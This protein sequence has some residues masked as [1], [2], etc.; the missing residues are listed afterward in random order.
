ML[1]VIFTFN[2][3]NLL[4]AQ[5]IPKQFK[6]KELNCNYNVK[7]GM[8]NGSYQ[9]F[10]P[11]GIKKSQGKFENNNRVERW[12]V[13]DSLG[14]EIC[15]R[16]YKNAIEFKQIFPVNLRNFNVLSDRDSN[17]LIK[18]FIV[19]EPMIYFYSKIWR[20]I[21]KENN[22]LLF[23]NESLSKLLINSILNQKITV[24]DIANEEFTIPLTLKQINEK[25][26]FDNLKINSFKIKEV[27]FMDT[28]RKISEVRILGICPI[29]CLKNDT[30]NNF[31]LF[32]LYYPDIRK[33][34]STKKIISKHEFP[35]LLNMDD[36]FVFRHF[37][38]KII[39]EDN[40]YDKEIKDYK[41]G[42]D[43]EIEAERI[44]LKLIEYEHDFWMLFSKN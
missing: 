11:N 9:S 39:K 2:A 1:L 44:N 18:D 26:D 6:N 29:A 21:S 25:F 3:E 7:D 32:W 15:E 10:Y 41:T 27:C 13:W 34:L 14:N 24:F 43:I 37:S 30:V 35:E 22:P 33:V 16:Q 19:K 23:D 28:V 12:T 42:K 20:I 17:E 5:N 36:I 4:Y 38:S 40:T 8:L 31:G